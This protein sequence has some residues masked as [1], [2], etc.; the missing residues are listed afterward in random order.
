LSV[1][2]P[3]T[4]GRAHAVY[5]LAVL[6]SEYSLWVREPEDLVFA[7]LEELGI[8]FVPY[9]PLGRGGLSGATRRDRKFDA[10]DIRNGHP[11]FFEKKPWAEHRS[12]RCPDG[13]RGCERPD[14]GAARTWPG[15]SLKSRRSFLLPE[16]AALSGCTRTLRPQRWS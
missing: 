12:G 8:G 9:R 2:R 11:R 3:A 14:A 7:A 15:C 13:N 6:Q 16:L 4:I 5:P 1:A 10:S